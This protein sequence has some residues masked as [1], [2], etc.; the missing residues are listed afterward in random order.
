MTKSARRT[1]VFQFLKN[2]GLIDGEHGILVG[3][4]LRKF[5][6]RFT[7]LSSANLRGADL[8]EANLGGA[9]LIKAN[10]NYTN[11]R[12]AN[13][14]EA[15]LGGANLWGA[16]LSKATLTRATLT[17]AKL[18]GANLGRGRSGILS[19][20]RGAPL[21]EFGWPITC[22]PSGWHLGKIQTGMPYPC[23]GFQPVAVV[24]VLTWIGIVAF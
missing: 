18:Q 7:E 20:N 9:N 13:L 21:K 5:D 24:Q 22:F 8:S 6:L 17:K 10:L 19:D 11:L 1:S 14:R 16:I 4:N 15:N 2:A 3:A 12:G 23:T